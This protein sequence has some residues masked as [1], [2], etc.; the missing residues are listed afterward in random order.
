MK[1]LVTGGG[2][3]IATAILEVFPTAWEV[4]ALQRDVCDVTKGQV[5]QSFINS[6]SP[7]VII[8]TAA[9]TAV[10]AA[11][12]NPEHAFD[13]NATAVAV[14]ATACH[15]NHIP[16]VHFSTDYVFDGIKNAAYVETDQPNPLNVYGLSKLKGEIFIREICPSHIILRVS[17]VFS[18]YKNNFVKTI[19]KLAEREEVLRVV[20]DQIHCPTSALSIAV[21]LKKILMQ[22]SDKSLGTYHYCQTPAVSWYEFAEKIIEFG[23]K[24]KTLKIKRIEP[25]TAIEFN[26]PAIRPSFSTLNCDKIMDCFGVCQSSWVE[27]LETIIRTINYEKIF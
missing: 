1:V 14:L 13:V 24:Y 17:S 16:L 25:I 22:L 6:F 21:V 3:Q 20:S 2:G 26:A 15:T 9:F 5:I 7:D 19:L 4:L 8:N 10:D 11:E 27:D 18:A 12:K 23:Q